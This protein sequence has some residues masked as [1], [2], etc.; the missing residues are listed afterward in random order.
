MHKN[1]VKIK[2]VVPEISS[3]IDTQTDKQTDMQ[4]TILRSPNRG[5]VNTYLCG[6]G[7]K[8]LFTAHELN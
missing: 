6:V 8:D 1:L 7:S 3:R 5:E 2:R 4:I